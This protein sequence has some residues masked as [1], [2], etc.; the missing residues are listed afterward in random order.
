MFPILCSL[1]KVGVFSPY[2]DIMLTCVIQLAFF[3]FLRC[4]EFTVLSS[5]DYDKCI[6]IQDIW[7]NSD[8]SGILHLRN[9]KTDPF[10]KGVDIH[11]FSNKY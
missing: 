5:Q 1:L 6:R 11:I 7:F 4:G 10:H 9:S 3:G 2:T 8:Y